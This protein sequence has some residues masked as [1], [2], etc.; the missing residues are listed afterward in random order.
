MA[1][2]STLARTLLLTKREIR[3][4]LSAGA[5]DDQL[6]YQAIEMAQE[7]LAATYD[8]RELADQWSKTASTR[9]TAFPTTGIGGSTTGINFDRDI[10]AWT[11][12]NNIWQPLERGISLEEYNVQDSDGGETQDPA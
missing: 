6:L 4:S 10:E 8:W 11:S 1:C 12:Y 3:A 7:E 5:A 9:W 2:G